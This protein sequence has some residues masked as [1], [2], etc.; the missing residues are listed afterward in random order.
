MRN[1]NPN[2]NPPC[3]AY[4]C[5]YLR[6]LGF[7]ILEVESLDPIKK[8]LSLRPPASKQSTNSVLMVVPV[9]FAHNAETAADNS[10]MHQLKVEQ[11]EG[12]APE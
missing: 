6:G 7:S 4:S 2:P 12:T 5:R 1:P 3:R 11:S 9:G 10:F 8:E